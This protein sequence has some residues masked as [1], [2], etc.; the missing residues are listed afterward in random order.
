MFDCT[1]ARSFL[2][3]SVS[4]RGLGSMPSIVAMIALAWA[5]VTADEIVRVC[6]SD[7]IAM[8]ARVHVC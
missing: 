7:C 4:A 6:L 5:R 1:H 8:C 2:H 3:M